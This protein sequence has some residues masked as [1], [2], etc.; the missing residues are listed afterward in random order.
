[1]KHII[2][3]AKSIYESKLE[4]KNFNP[5]VDKGNVFTWLYTIRVLESKYNCEL[6]PLLIYQGAYPKAFI[7]KTI[8]TFTPLEREN[9]KREHRENRL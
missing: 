3:E 5:L 7:N 9:D 6:D 2:L 8:T 1:M 4:I